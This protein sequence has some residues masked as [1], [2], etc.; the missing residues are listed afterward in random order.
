MAERQKLEDTPFDEIVD[1]ATQG[2][3]AALLEDGGKGMRRA[4]FMWLSTAAQWRELRLD[5]EK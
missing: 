3:H 2:I 4:V 1:E 5:A